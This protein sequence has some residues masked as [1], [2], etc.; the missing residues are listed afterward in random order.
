M[1]ENRTEA[2]MRLHSEKRARE[3]ALKRRQKESDGNNDSTEKTG[4]VNGGLP[5]N[6]DITESDDAVDPSVEPP[7]WAG[8]AHVTT[9]TTITADPERVD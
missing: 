6:S 2:E 3:L 5:E 9:G 8:E 4:A 7:S 1:F